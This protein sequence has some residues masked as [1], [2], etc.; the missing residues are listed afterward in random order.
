[1]L[2]RCLNFLA[3][4]YLLSQPLRNDLIAAIVHSHSTGCPYWMYF[5]LYRTIRSIRPQYVLELGTGISTI[6]IAHAL[7]LNGRGVVVSMEES[8]EWFQTA[9]RLI[10]NHLTAY[11]DLR[12]SPA[13]EKTYGLFRG[14]GYKEIPEH[15]YGVV[16]V[17]GPAYLTNPKGDLAFNFDVIEVARYCTPRV[18]IDKR[19]STRWVYQQL[20]N[21]VHQDLTKTMTIF[22][23]SSP[24]N[25]TKVFAQ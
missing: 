14:S 12:L 17:D 2:S 13:V 9:L 5:K 8:E 20:F 19:N 10:P 23:V 22:D 25:P 15:P 6:V 11:I 24:P 18:L 1:M 21:D 7:K 3:K 4:K 16:F